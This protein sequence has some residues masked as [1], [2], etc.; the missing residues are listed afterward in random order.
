MDHSIKIREFDAAMQRYHH[1]P[2]F[3]LLSTGLSAFIILSQ[4]ITYQYLLTS[5]PSDTSL[6]FCLLSV[7]ASYVVADFVGGIAHMYMDNN[8]NYH[9]TF[10]P[11]IA[12]FH[13]HHQKPRYNK[14]NPLLV[15]FFES[16]TKWW[17]AGYLLALIIAQATL[18]MPFYIQLF[19]V[20][21]GVLSSFAEVSHYWCHQPHDEHSLIAFL[22]RHRLLLSKEH[23][24]YHHKY[25]NQ[26]YAFLN[27][28]TD[29]LLNL[30]AKHQYHGY[31]ESADRHAGAYT[32]R[33]TANRD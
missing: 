17:L 4:L 1:V 19:F 13:L 10:G 11:L 27:G 8:V 12:A 23:H 24:A 5:A 9:S 15:Y 25:D 16:G 21:F 31:K 3:K 14:V 26:N 33:Q 6:L 32:G 20:S 28:M 29:P 7:T 30:I 2:L 18:T 22:Q